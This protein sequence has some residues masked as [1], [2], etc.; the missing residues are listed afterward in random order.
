MNR[1]RIIVLGVAAAAAIGA[2]YMAKNLASPKQEAIAE[3]PPPEPAIELTE[4][5]MLAKD[6]PMGEQIGSNL[7]WQPWPADAL[8]E[9]FI[10]RGQEP[11]AL[12]ELRN[13]IARVNLYAGEPLRRAKLINEGSSFMSAMLPPGKRAIATQIAADTSA[14]GF[15]LPGDYVDV[16]MT[17]RA[18]SDTTPTGFITETILENVRVLAIDQ[19]IHED[20]EGRRVKLGETATLELSPDQAEV[21]TAAQ[22]MADRLTLALRSIADI[23]DGAN[24]QGSYL[25]TGAGSGNSIRLI[26]SGE[27]TIVGTRR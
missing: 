19:T 26:R 27:V 18:D 5:L 2:G 8:N 14:G 9:H 1:S 22:Q 20:E 11:D 7:R 12:E 23:S 10:T 3:L 13:G 17:R 4:V 21:I 16:I 6:V 24:N 15:I 25:V